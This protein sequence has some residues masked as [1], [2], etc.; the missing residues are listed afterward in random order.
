MGS[1]KSVVNLNLPSCTCMDFKKYHWPCKHICALFIN[2]PGHSFNDFPIKFKNNVFISSD[3]R[4]S[5]TYNNT[6][7]TI[8]NPLH[9]PI[10]VI[11]N[12][13]FNTNENIISNDPNII[14]NEETN[15]INIPVQCR[16]VLK[17][18]NRFN[19]FN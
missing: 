7:S 17:K 11:N 15:S 9:T 1:N 4:F 5:I 6:N 18:N 16:E 12:D 3:P 19:L 8:A 14:E 2:V 13:N 10:T